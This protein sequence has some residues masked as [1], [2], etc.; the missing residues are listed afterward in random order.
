MSSGMGYCRAL[1]SNLFSSLTALIGFFVGVPISTTQDSAKKWIFAIT[2]GM[3]L[4]ISL[5]DMVSN[6]INTL[7]LFNLYMQNKEW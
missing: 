7:V 5:V 4:Y 3:F 6:Q 1:L 2:A